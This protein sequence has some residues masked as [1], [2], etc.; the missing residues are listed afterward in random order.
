MLFSRKKKLSVVVVIYNIPREAPKTL[1]SLSATYQRY[2]HTDDYEVIVVDN[3]SNPPFDKR[4][5]DN[6]EGNFSLIRINNASHSPVQAI[7]CGIANAKGEVIGVMIDG[8][9]LVSPGLL[10]FAVHGAH[11]Y[12]H[13][14]AASLG[15]FVGYD[16]QRLALE[17]GY[18]DRTQED[19][20]LNSVNWQEDGYQLFEISSMD[21]SSAEGWFFPILESNALFMK[22]SMWKTLG[23]FDERF[24]S[25]AGG[26]ANFD[27]LKRAGELPEAQVVILLGEAT[28]HQIHGGTATNAFEKRRAELVIQWCNQYKKIRGY[29]Y[30]GRVEPKNPVTYLGKLPRSVLK[31]FTHAAA[32]RICRLEAPSSLGL[33]FDFQ[34]TLFPYTQHPDLNIASVIALAYQE[35]TARRYMVATDIIRLLRSRAPNDLELQRLL[36]FT[37]KG[38]KGFVEHPNAEYFYTLGEAHRL[39]GETHLAVS[40]YQKALTLDPNLRTA[41]SR[42]AYIQMNGE[43]YYAWLERFYKKLAPEIIIEIGIYEG[44]SLRLACPPTLAIGVDPNPSVSYKLKSETH[45]FPETSDNFFA[46]RG[47]DALLAGRQL[48]V[49]FIDGLHLFEQVLKDFI[50]L[51]T[52]CGP[53]SVILIHDTV[54]LNEVTQNRDCNTIFH[55]GDVWKIVPCLK[56]Y[57]PDLDI[58]T[59]ATPPTGLTVL[60]GLNPNSRILSDRYEEVVSRFMDY[61][62]TELE[63]NKESI[64]NIVPNTLD[65]VISRL[66][67]RGIIMEQD[68][69]DIPVAPRKCTSASS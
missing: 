24:D 54:P 64:L 22:R 12:P 2:I 59:I 17:S 1:F 38:I 27:I 31:H 8:A 46:R 44:A 36:P 19:I 13:A 45:I 51:E 16:I 49:A 56:Y 43:N 11:L 37:A 15:Y 66:K 65:S 29:P 5:I 4:V 6:L 41:H 20:L 39:L 23:G 28:F 7:N 21:E 32:N 10:H 30:P 61:S 69:S 33:D 50:N 25:I 62:F 35:Y 55:T 48:G 67:A 57:R 68:E 18:Y 60:T 9:R 52:Y 3:G 47:P 14:I 40:H 26:L 63:K 34:R 58:F 42:L 53:C